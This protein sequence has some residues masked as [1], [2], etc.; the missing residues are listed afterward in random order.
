MGDGDGDSPDAADGDPG[1]AIYVDGERKCSIGTTTPTEK[2]EV[3]GK[4]KA[5]GV[6]HR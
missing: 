2:L 4:V 5:P 6:Y 3:E 1:D